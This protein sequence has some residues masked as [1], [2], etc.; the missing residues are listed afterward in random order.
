VDRDAKKAET[1][2]RRLQEALAL[3]TDNRKLGMK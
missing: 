3:L 2:A 1:R